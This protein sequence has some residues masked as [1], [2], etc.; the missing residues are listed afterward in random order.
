VKLVFPT[1]EMISYYIGNNFLP[2][3]AHTEAGAPRRTSIKGRLVNIVEV[4]ELL[5]FEA[6]TQ[7]Q[8]KKLTPC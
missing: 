8:K 5:G 6:L 2:G 3:R 1:K 4:H 7:I